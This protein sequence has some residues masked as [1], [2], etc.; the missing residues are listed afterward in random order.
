VPHDLERICLRCLEK[1]P[2][3]RY[4]G[5][6][7]LAENLRQ[8]LAGKS[9]P[10]QA[11]DRRQRLFRW[12]R[13]RPV[14]AGAFLLLLLAGALAGLGSFL[15]PSSPPARVASDATFPRSSP[16]KAPAV[17]PD[18]PK[19]DKKEAPLSAPPGWTEYQFPLG[20][21]VVWF[22][23]VPKET[24]KLVATK[25]GRVAV[26][27]AN[28]VDA[29]SG[30]HWNACCAETRK[31]PVESVAGKFVI[32][33]D[34]AVRNIQGKV[35]RER[36]LH[37]GPQRGRE[38]YVEAPKLGK[39]VVRMHYYVVGQRLYQLMVV[40]AREEVEGRAAEQ[41]FASFRLTSER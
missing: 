38:V 10:G 2:A 3:Q 7:A 41:F 31:V 17:L 11:T 25:L 34:G 37:L 5:A 30:L 4:G 27:L 19:P 13:R 23:G 22:P 12:W 40:G 1:D 15:W 8:F 28:F 20:K 21:G 35:V 6:A 39:A 16:D 29:E 24:Q 36:D 26:H 9:L 18:G 32:D 14:L 33:P